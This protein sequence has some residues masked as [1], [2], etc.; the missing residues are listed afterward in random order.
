MLRPTIYFFHPVLL[1]LGIRDGINF[2][3]RYMHATVCC[4][5]GVCVM[6]RILVTL[7]VLLLS[8]VL[9]PIAAMAQDCFLLD[10]D[11]LDMSS[12][13]SAAYVASHLSAQTTG[14]RVRKYVSD[15]NELTAT[16]RLTVMQAETSAVVF[17]KN[18]GS[19]SGTFDSGDIY[20]P[21]VDHNTI[22]Y[23]IT[24]YIED[25]TYAMPFMQL[26]I[27]LSQN[28]ACTYGVRLRDYDSKLTSGWLMGTMLDLDTLRSQGALSMPLC[29]S[30]AYVVGEATVS[31]A[32]DQMSVNL[33]FVQSANVEV[34]NV[35]VYFIHDLVNLVADPATSGQPAYGVSEAINV[36][37]IS[38]G[39]L[40]VPML[41]SYDPSGLSEFSYD[42][43]NMV[44]ASQLS[45]W[46]LNVQSV[47]SSVVGGETTT[48]DEPL[49][50]IF[51]DE[52]AESTVEDNGID[53]QKQLLS[54][55]DDP[56][57]YMETP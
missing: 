17:D 55:E 3:H 19:V 54:P 18:Y 40:Y 41:I 42:L 36:A 44:L 29:A 37:G 56:A 10:V 12:L 8:A 25:W 11:S 21:Y 30:N 32:G 31:L 26:P 24:V 27:R 9:F 2:Y 50:S 23:V 20:L 6:K 15:S 48:Q 52:Q 53:P 57:T 22:P 13:N 38:N 46:N 4:I 7:F 33:A 47:D 39:L 34:H 1:M 14:I 49:D 5:K 45:L 43:S 28:T 51:T 35:S 16:V